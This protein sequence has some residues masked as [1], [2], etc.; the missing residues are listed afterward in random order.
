MTVGRF[1]TRV[2]ITQWKIFGNHDLSQNAAKQEAWLWNEIFL[3]VL[4]KL[5][6]IF[7]LRFFDEKCILRFKFGSENYGPK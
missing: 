6:G 7:L 5:A 1:F 2:T 3:D 4:V